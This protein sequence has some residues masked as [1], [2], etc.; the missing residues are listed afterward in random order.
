[1]RIETNVGGF[2]RTSHGIPPNSRN[3]GFNTIW[4]IVNREVLTIRFG[5]NS[6]S[7][8]DHTPLTSFENP[9]EPMLNEESQR[10][11]ETAKLTAQSANTAQIRA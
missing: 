2:P 6:N 8:S 7:S 10:V 1:M 5:F 4:T 9:I 3:Y 11:A